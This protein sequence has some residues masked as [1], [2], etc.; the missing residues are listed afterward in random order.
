MHIKKYKIIVLP[1]FKN[2]FYKIFGHV[3]GDSKQ[4]KIYYKL[5]NQIKRKV[6]QLEDMPKIYVKTQACDELG[7]RYRKIIVKQYIILYSIDEQENKIY[8]SH[9][10]YKKSN[11]FNKL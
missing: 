6:Q 5:V 1:Q 8:I 4:H 2:E 3:Y 9:I 10:F 7:R 11:Y